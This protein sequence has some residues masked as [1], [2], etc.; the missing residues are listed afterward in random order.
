[1]PTQ[2]DQGLVRYD[3]LSR[4]IDAAYAVDEVKDIRDKALAMEVYFRQAKNPEPE[5]RACEIRLRAERK[6]GELL[7]DIEKNQGAKGNPGGQGAKLVQSFDTTAQARPR[8]SDLGITRD[9]SSR[10][11][12]LA[13]VP[14]EE[15][16]AALAAPEKPSTTSIIEAAKPKPVEAI[17]EESLWIWGPA[18]RLERKNI[19]QRNFA[20]VVACLPPALRPQAERLAR[21]VG[22]WLRGS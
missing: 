7:R 17:D 18:R 2:L 5:R 22:A 14:K 19:M 3:E 8:L 1:V 10:W 16:E 21:E 15:S 11:Q 6:A 4:A 9:Q 20:D 13:A 12:K